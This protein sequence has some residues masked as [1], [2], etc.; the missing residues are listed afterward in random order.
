M[1][2]PLAYS[3]SELQIPMFFSEGSGKVCAK[4]DTLRGKIYG[5]MFVPLRAKPNDFQTLRRSWCVEGSTSLSDSKLQQFRRPRKPQLRS[6]SSWTRGTRWEWA[7]SPA[8][9]QVRPRRGG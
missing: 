8:L 6:R 7:S 9:L 3:L 4:P 5:S 1:A 2:R